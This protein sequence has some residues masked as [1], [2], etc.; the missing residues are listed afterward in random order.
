MFE[1]CSGLTTIGNTF[2]VPSSCIEHA[3]N[4][5]KDCHSLKTIPNT[6]TLSNVQNS[7]SGFF[8]NCSSLIEIP[9]TFSLNSNIKNIDH[10]FKNCYNI[11]TL[12]EN[13][14][15][16]NSL[17]SAIEAFY[18]CSSI[19]EFSEELIE[20]TP[21]TIVTLSSTFEN[22]FNLTKIPSGLTLKDI[23]T[24]ICL[25]KTFKNCNKLVFENTFE[26]PLSAAS[27]VETFA[28]CYEIKMPYEGIFLPS[29]VNYS[30]MFSNCINL[31]N[32]TNENI[33][34]YNEAKDISCIFENCSSLI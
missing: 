3:N 21:S 15:F 9:N 14:S 31:T 4:V 10:I 1:G 5:F 8:E 26:L 22:C 23:N 33:Q 11:N 20:T 32:F 2:T 28:H 25:D 30:G 34:L 19:I 12:T 17:S 27:C 29:S 24:N 18:N 6:L 7:V 16:G 13:V